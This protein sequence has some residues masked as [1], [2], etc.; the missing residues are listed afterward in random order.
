L[1]LGLQVDDARRVVENLTAVVG[2]HRPDSGS[3]GSRHS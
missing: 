2:E 3:N 1:A